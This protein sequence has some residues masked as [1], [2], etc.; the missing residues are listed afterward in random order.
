MSPYPKISRIRSYDFDALFYKKT[1]S[2]IDEK[3]RQ[4]I[5]CKGEKFAR[6]N[7]KDKFQPPSQHGMLP[8]ETFMINRTPF[9]QT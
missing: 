1:M 2:A 6:H 3:T 7:V 4:A 8:K 9:L 5:G